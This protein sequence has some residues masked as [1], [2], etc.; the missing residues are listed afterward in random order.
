MP[1]LL[2]FALLLPLTACDR[3]P[4]PGDAYTHTSSGA[5]IVVLNVG[6]A[7]DLYATHS[8]SDGTSRKGRGL[9][10][11]LATQRTLLK[12]DSSAQAISYS[13]DTIVDPSQGSITEIRIV[14]LDSL[15]AYE[16]VEE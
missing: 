9:T 8:A 2:F 13:I 11:S 6:Q 7:S 4:Q 1:R 14:P 5:Q 10:S 15:D 3:G 12:A 16:R